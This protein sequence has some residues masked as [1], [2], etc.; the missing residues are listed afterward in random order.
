M[1]AALGSMA[2]SLQIVPGRLNSW[3]CA[4]TMRDEKMA[5]TMNGRIAIDTTARCIGLD[6][7]HGT[8]FQLRIG[9]R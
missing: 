1:A 4:R 9:A 3:P 7:I 8:F 5:R 2:N 6:F